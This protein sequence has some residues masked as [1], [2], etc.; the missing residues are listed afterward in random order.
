MA[1]KIT[2][3]A[4]GLIYNDTG[5]KI[6]LFTYQDAL[7]PCLVNLKKAVYIAQRFKE[8]TEALFEQPIVWDNVKPVELSLLI[9]SCHS[10]FQVFRT[11]QANLIYC[12][13]HII[14]VQDYNNKH[15]R[16]LVLECCDRDKLPYKNVVV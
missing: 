2:P 5:S 3:Y 11:F 10:S 4:I 8:T 9:A 7:W 13:E 14:N 15:L 6:G 12:C 1:H 16:A